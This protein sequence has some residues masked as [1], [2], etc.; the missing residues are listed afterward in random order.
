MHRNSHCHKKLGY[1]NKKTE[2]RRQEAE[3]T[4]LFRI[5]TTGKVGNRKSPAPDLGAGESNE[6]ELKDNTGGNPWP[7]FWSLPL[8]VNQVLRD[9]GSLI[10]RNTIEVKDLMEYQFSHSLYQKDLG[11]ENK[12]SHLAEPVHSSQ[13]GSMTRDGS[14]LMTKPKEF[15]EMCDDDDGRGIGRGSSALGEVVEG[16]SPVYPFR[17]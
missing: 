6:A 17:N 16:D 7:L 15:N 2:T 4:L 3:L 8:P 14:R 9:L 12:V 1:S 5:Q 10:D 13:D 11:Q